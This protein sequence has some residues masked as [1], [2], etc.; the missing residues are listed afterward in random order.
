VG[1]L[2]VIARHTGDA[3]E[4]SITDDGRGIDMSTI[5]ETLVRKKLVSPEEIDNLSRDQLLDYLF[6]PGFST[7][8]GVTNMSG[9]GVGLDV[10]KFTVERLGGEVRLESEPG[11]GSSISMRL[12]LAMST[13]RCLLILVSGRLAA[14]PSS[15]VEKVILLKTDDT[16][17]IGDTQVIEYRGQNIHISSLADAL[18]IVSQGSSDSSNTKIVLI[19]SFGE[20]RLAFQV[21]DVIEYTQVILRPLGD[22]LERV[23]NISGIS[24]LG[25]GEMALVLNPAD[26]VRVAGSRRSKGILQKQVTEESKP[27]TL[28]ILVVDDSIAT[29]TLEKNLLESAGFIV[30]TATDGYNALQVLET[31]SCDIVISDVQMPNMDGFEL[32]RAIKNR[33]GDQIPVVIISALGSDED[34]AKGL[35]A[36]ADAYIVKKDLTQRELVSTIE[37][38]V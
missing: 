9:R 18:G 28:H 21:D 5:R 4:L 26:L 34:K 15:N 16:K 27:K 33:Y 23:P 8:S 14:I 30:T 24:L 36:G 11:K 6:E 20:R 19:I 37:Q 10:V 38:L 32:A 35:E 17:I 31:E 22:L 29:R 25:S 12:P 7:R 1:T 2:S 13:L 3:V